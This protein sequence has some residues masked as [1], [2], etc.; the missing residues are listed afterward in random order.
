MATNTPKLGLKKP[1]PNVETDWGSRLNES[2]DIL[3]DAM[4][5]VNVAG[6]GTVTV[7]D[8]G[9]GNVT[10]SGVASEGVDNAI[11]GSD[12]ITVTSGTSTTDVRGFQ[13][14]FVSSS[15]SLQ[16][17]IDT[18]D[19]SVTL[20]EA[21]DNGD[22]VI[23]TTT[24][25]PVVIS[26][27]GELETGPLTASGLVLV[28]PT[29]LNVNDLNL[30]PTDD[31]D[32][33]IG[34]RQ[35]LIDFV[36]DGTR[37]TSFSTNGIF[38]LGLLSLGGGSEATPWLRDNT[39]TDTG[40]FW[41]ADDEF[42][43]VAGGTT[44]LTVSGSD[45]LTDGVGINGNLTVTGTIAANGREVALR[46]DFDIVTFGAIGD[47]TTDDGPA[48]QAAIDAAEA[49]G[50]GTVYAGS[51]SV[52]YKISTEVIMKKN[53]SVVGEHLPSN[54]IL[55]T[56]E[57]TV[58]LRGSDIIMFNMTGTNRVSDR[59]GR[60]VFRGI[61]F[62]DGTNIGNSSMI[63]GKY[64]DNMLLENCTFS[65]PTGNTTNGHLIDAE[66][67][68]DWKLRN[69]VFK[70]Y[71]DTSPAKYAINL[72]NGE[73][74]NSNFWEFVGCKFY[75]G[76]GK[77]IFFDASGAGSTR[78]T[79]FFFT[80][81]KFEDSGSNSEVYIDG[82]ASHVFINYCVFTSGDSRYINV[83]ALSVG[84]K[85]ENNLF[86]LIGDTATEYIT[87]FGKDVGIHNNNFS[88]IGVNTSQLIQVDFSSGGG[89][90]TS[91]TGNDFFEATAGTTPLVATSGTL[92]NLMHIGNNVG[93]RKDESVSGTVT[94]QPWG[95]ARIHSATGTVSGTLPDGGEIGSQKVI[96]MINADNTST[97]S[98]TN[99]ETSS[100]EVFT[101][102]STDDMLILAWAGSRWVTVANSG[103]VT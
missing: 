91:I 54:N 6:K 67:C 15:G 2:L 10:I 97:I 72:F 68:W 19:A 24:N 95:V 44:R 88:S 78:N 12:G 82:D 60:S 79:Q 41:P 47:G 28:G 9:S 57:G 103:P 7:T 23:I 73:D 50:G 38:S 43:L 35:S 96:T 87:V 85:I 58:F 49:A 31:L 26:G 53:I 69:V 76:I 90:G 83:S 30:G 94:L 89:I 37:R 36:V 56:P 34:F 61:H 65:A 52:S 63:F 39:D 70:H 16:S 27:T 20:Q 84:W 93:D 98:V 71:G 25:K 29:H 32:T 86:S 100:P 46:S 42:A 51:P 40:A 80:R 22:G 66:E 33:G 4:L 99:H 1:I 64:A 102:D 18:I 74:D 92:S 17:Q 75:N 55:L 59:V 45:P 21:Y 77:A 5:T 14:E 48:I 13:A 3:D 11:T 62:K 101:F 8:D 81:C